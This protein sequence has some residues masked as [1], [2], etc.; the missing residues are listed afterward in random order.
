LPDR[1]RF[2]GALTDVIIGLE[3]NDMDEYSIVAY[4]L[5]E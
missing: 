1:V 4:R 3:R 5:S 2:A